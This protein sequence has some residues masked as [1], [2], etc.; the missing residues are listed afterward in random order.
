M[1]TT[2]DNAEHKTTNMCNKRNKIK[3]IYTSIYI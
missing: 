2:L 3:R 1:N